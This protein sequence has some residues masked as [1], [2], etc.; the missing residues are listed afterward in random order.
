MFALIAVLALVATQIPATAQS[1]SLRGF[2]DDAVAAQ[3]QREEQFRKVPD[4]ARLKEHG[5]NGG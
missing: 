5:G 3:R 1:P 2:P 4:A